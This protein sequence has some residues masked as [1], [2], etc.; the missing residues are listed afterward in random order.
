MVAVIGSDLLSSLFIIYSHCNLVRRSPSP[1]DTRPSSSKARL[2]GSLHATPGVAGPRT[3][4]EGWVLRAWACFG[5]GTEFSS[6]DEEKGLWHAPM[7]V[8]PAL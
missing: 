1:L 3:P 6:E 2:L 4:A 8:S 7:R 5:S